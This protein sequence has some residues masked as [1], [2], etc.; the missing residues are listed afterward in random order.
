MHSQPIQIWRG[1]FQGDS[2]LPLYN[3]YPINTQA[4]QSW[5]WISSTCSWE[6]NKSPYT[7]HLKLLSA[8]E[9][10]LKNEIKI[11]K[12]ANMNFGLEKCAKI[13]LKL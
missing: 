9:E 5:L 11:M 10:D 1:I 7:D 4:D 12:D 2:F 3:T 8:S 13:C 6:E